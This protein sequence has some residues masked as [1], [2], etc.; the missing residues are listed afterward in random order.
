MRRGRRFGQLALLLAGIVVV[1]LASASRAEAFIYWTNNAHIVGP[2]IGRA[3]NDGSGV[4]QTFIAGLNDPTGVAVDSRHVYWANRGTN[5]IGRANI[6]GSGVD[7]D[8]ITVVGEENPFAVAISSSRIWWANLGTLGTSDDGSIARANLN[9]TGADFDHIPGAPQVN[10]PCGTAVDSGF[11]YWTNGSGSVNPTIWRSPLGDPFP[12][13]VVG[14]SGSFLSC[15]PSVGG[16][17]IYWANASSGIRRDDVDP[18]TPEPPED[19]LPVNAF[20]GTAVHASRLYW[21]NNAEGTISRANLDGSSPDFAFITGA[22]RPLGLAID[23]RGPGG[24]GGCDDLTLGKAKK[25]KRK[26]TAKLTAEVGCA[27]TL[28]VGGKGVKPAEREAG[29]AGEVKLPVKAK[30]KKRKKLRQRGKAKVEVVVTFTP[31]GD[32]PVTVDKKV[33]LVKK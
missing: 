25:N 27:G 1:S 11:V 10:I 12:E 23:S 32:D 26:G 30:G 4:D 6:D 19:L 18:D 31:D 2:T 24:G 20:G 16:S 8:F 14:D 13:Q 5:T 21:A 15:W 22:D 9:G 7:K 28:E 33:K 29:G 17:H 3:S